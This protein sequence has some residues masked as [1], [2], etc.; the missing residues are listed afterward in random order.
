[1]VQGNFSQGDY[2][3]DCYGISQ[4]VLRALFGVWINVSAAVVAICIRSTFRSHLKNELVSGDRTVNFWRV[5]PAVTSSEVFELRNILA[6]ALIRGDLTFFIASTFCILTAIVGAASTTISNHVIVTNLI[7]RN[8][9]VPGR[10]VTHEHSSL[11]GAVVEL[12]S[13]VNALYK[14]S[15]PLEELFDFIPSDDVSWVYQTEQWNN[16]W[17]GRCSFVK[18]EAVDLVVYPTNT[19]NYQDEIPLLGN[20]IPRWATMDRTKQGAAYVGFYYGVTAN[21]TGAWRDQVVTYVFGTAPANNPGNVAPSV[22]ISLVNY[23][24]HNIARDPYSTY[25][26]T[27]FKSD[28]HVVDCK[29]DNSVSSR[30]D[31]AYAEGGNYVNAAGNVANVRTFFRK[32]MDPGP[33]LSLY[34]CIIVPWL[35]HRSQN[36][37]LSNLPHRKCCDIGRRSC[38]SKIHSILTLSSVPLQYRN[39]S[40]RSV[41][42]LW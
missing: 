36:K 3:I 13:R 38:L 27:T 14:A 6:R 8:S 21:G 18:H 17:Q 23:L 22:N 24:A 40:F 29:F 25:L 28:V 16:T 41:Y 10:L 2:F 34:R 20:Y 1:M 42:L 4:S 9:I 15:A 35:R 32:S 31:Q 30:E 26:Q 33:D 39:G 5:S 7:T 12:T 37:R 11:A 19:T